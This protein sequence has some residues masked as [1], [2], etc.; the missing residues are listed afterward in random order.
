MQEKELLQLIRKARSKDPDAFSS[1]IPPPLHDLYRVAISI[2]M[3]DEDAADAIQDTILGCWE[4]LHTLK[5]EKYFKTW[6]TRILINH[7]YDMRKKQQRMT[8]M[9]DYEE[10]VAEDQYNVELK[11]AL[12]QLDEKYRIVMVL[13]YSEGYQT[14]EIAELLEIPRSTVQTRLQRGR[15]KLEAYYR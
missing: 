13:Y 11:E 14:G 7:C 15:E 12:G 8:T 4:K 10:L 3:N 9:E 1:L 5:Q 2:L 6:L